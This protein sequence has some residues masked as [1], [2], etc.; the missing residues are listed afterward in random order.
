MEHEGLSRASK[1][2]V[3]ITGSGQFGMHDASDA[4]QLIQREI[5]READL[6]VGVVRDEAMDG[7][8]VRVMLIASG[9]EQEAFRPPSKRKETPRPLP[10][11]ALLEVRDCRRPAGLRPRSSPVV[12]GRPAIVGRPASPPPQPSPLPAMSPQEEMHAQVVETPEPE[13]EAPERVPIEAEPPD[14]HV[15]SPYDFIPSPTVPAEDEADESQTMTRPSF[16]RR[17]SFFG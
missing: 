13:E 17:R 5:G 1:V 12:V 2:L 10:A 6:T 14:R 3:N 15:G 9:F 4:L 16:F 11:G 8:D 7:E